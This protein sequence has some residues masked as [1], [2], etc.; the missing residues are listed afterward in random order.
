[1]AIVKEYVTPEGCRIRFHDDYLPK[2][3]EE[4]RQRQKHMYE[5]CGQILRAAAQRRLEEE[6][7][8]EN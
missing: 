4:L 1:M 8:S 3:E 7:K 5:V 6:K 2:T